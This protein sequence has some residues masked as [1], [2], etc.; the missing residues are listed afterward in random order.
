MPVP[1]VYY[2]FKDGDG[3]G[4]GFVMQWLEGETLGSRIARM[5]QS[6]MP[7]PLA[8]QCGQL[9]ARIHTVR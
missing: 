8:Y 3:L 6:K 2:I 9:L 1:Q 7:Q 4:E 5:P